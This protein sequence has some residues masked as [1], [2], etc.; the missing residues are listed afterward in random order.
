VCCIY[1]LSSVTSDFIPTDKEEKEAI[2]ELAKQ[3]YVLRILHVTQTLLVG[4]QEGHLACKK[5]GM[6]EMGT[7]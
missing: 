3:W 5:W 6:V 7:G 1:S 4:R 2:L